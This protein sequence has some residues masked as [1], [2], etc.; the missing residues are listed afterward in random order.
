M[1]RKTLTSAVLAGMAGVA[2]IASISNAVN[3]NPDGLGEVL[4]YPFYTVNGGNDTLISVVNTTNQTKAVKVRFLESLNSQE[5][6]DFNL[7]LSPFDVWVAAI[8]REPGNEAGAAVVAVADNSCT[9]P[10]FFVQSEGNINGLPFV[11]FRTL[12]LTDEIGPSA[13]RTREG[14][15]EMIE[16]G[17]LDP[18]SDFGGAAIHNTS[19]VPANCGALNA[20]WAPG[21]TFTNNPGGGV[22]EPSG[23][24]FGGGSLI[25]VLGGFQAAYN[26]DAIAGFYD[27]DPTAPNNSTIDLHTAP[28]SLLPSLRSA[29]TGGV[30]VT[31][32]VFDNA[33]VITSEWNEPIDAVSAIFMRDFVYNEYA[34]DTAL[35]A[36]T[37]WVLTF[38]T[39]RF[40]VNPGIN[41]PFTSDFD[42]D[43]A[44]EIVG[45]N[46][47]NREE[48]TTVGGVNFS[49]VITT[50][51][52]LC[53]EAQVITFGE[54]A[55]PSTILG[56]PTSANIAVDGAGFE[57]GWAQ[58]QLDADG[59]QYTSDDPAG[60]DTYRGLPVTGFSLQVVQNSFL[61]DGDGNRV[62]SN[63]AGM[64]DHR[65]SR[66]IVGS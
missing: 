2:G 21:G 7:Y 10:S 31:S 64:F 12:Q 32:N 11:R 15:V 52:Q 63:Y 60:G 62:L 55:P 28:S 16:M 34:I 36:A 30:R 38:P 22:D 8:T 4:I 54:G 13:A 23:G 66:D 40:Y 37:E 45:I 51:P 65:Y 41:A 53:F 24:L 39:K 35:N 43:G 29:N 49:P 59:Q 48:L 50:R 9:V 6:L 58:I 1:K 5:V 17:T 42:E 20:A 26:A 33:R 61:V 27:P 18:A 46:F 14:Y 47:W 3:L 44:C 19:G 56:S 57:N 25:N